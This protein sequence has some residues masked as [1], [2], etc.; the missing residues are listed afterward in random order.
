MNS[1]FLILEFIMYA[2]TFYILIYKKELGILYLPSLFFIFTI[3]TPTIPIGVFYALV[4][5]LIIS[6]LN[7]RFDLLSQNPA[8][9]LLLFYFLILLTAAHAELKYSLVFSV[10]LFFI[11]IPLINL[12]YKHH[13]YDEI[14]SELTRASIIILVV[15]VTN[16]VLSTLTKYNPQSMY[17]INSGVFYGN[18]GYTDFNV[19]GIALFIV[20]LRLLKKNN[21]VLLAIYIIAFAF[22]M[23]TLRRSAML[24]SGLG[25]VF[26]FLTVMTQRKIGQSLLYLLL[27]VILGT[28]VY[29]KSDFASV[30]NER[31]ELR[32]LDEREFEEEK[33]FAEYEMVYKDMFILNKY[34]PW[35]GYGL[36][37]SA[38]NYGE[39]QFEDR[40]LHADLTSL[41][42]SS[43]LIGVFLYLI[44]I[45]TAFSMAFKAAKSK[46]QKLMVLYC[47]LTFLVYTITGRYSQADSMLLLFLVANL[48][49]AKVESEEVATELIEI[50]IGE[51]A[52]Q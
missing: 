14:F 8:A 17:G 16:A 27:A 23:L 39:G 51:R 34:S 19:I 52:L 43:G 32:R 4:A 10:L 40:T 24:V 31:Y 42:H 28:V 33:R 1:Y 29:F 20:L 9:V 22:V 50:E 26:A 44:M 3:I 41:A 11:S 18:L 25:V 35:F 36:F 13:T 47:V 21:F 37:N 45:L 5:L 46:G 2:F 49:M 38:G 48:G 15:F 6:I 30:F 12:I 7:K